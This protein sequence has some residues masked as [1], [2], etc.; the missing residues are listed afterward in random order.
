MPPTPSADDSSITK[1]RAKDRRQA[2]ARTQFWLAGETLMCA[3]PD[4]RAPVSVRQWLMLADCWRCGTSIELNESEVAAAERLMSAQLSLPEPPLPIA[5]GDSPSLLLPTVA[6]SEPVEMRLPVLPTLPRITPVPMPASIETVRPR[7]AERRERERNGNR[8][9]P[10]RKRTAFNW[11]GYFLSAL[12]AW[13]LSTIVHLIAVIILALITLPPN[14]IDEDYQI[15]LSTNI[16]TD[17]RYG[18]DAIKLPS[19]PEGELDLPPPSKEDLNDPI[20]RQAIIEADQV[21]KE[22]RVDPAPPDVPL[23]PI[24]E[25]QQRIGRE[26]GIKA[27]L[28]ARDPRLRVELVK[29]EGG[30]SLT[31]ASVARGLRWLANHQASDGCWRLDEFHH[32]GNCNC[33]Q[34]GSIEDDTAGTSLALLPFLGAGQTQFTGRYRKEVSGG[35]AWLVKKQKANGDLRSHTGNSG[36]YAHGQG[37]IVLCEAFA[38]TGDEALRRPAQRSIDFIV[39]AQYHDGGWRYMPGPPSQAGDTSVVGWQLMALQSARAAGLKVP[40]STL[41]RASKYLDGVSR[42]DRSLYSYQVNSS[43]THVM[44]AEALLCRVYLGWQRDEPALHRG[45]NWLTESNA[46]K[47]D[48]PDIYY[49]Y[50]GTQAMHH[51]GGPMWDTWNFKMRDLLVQSQ[52]KNGH[53]AG[54]WSPRGPHAEVGGRI[55]MT[56]LSVCTLEVYYRHLPIFRKIET[57]EQ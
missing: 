4:C 18:G 33:G 36:M 31:E 39:A 8:S 30:T 11:L 2:A 52:Q 21:A 16:R 14:L 55:Y 29:K 24:E 28:A 57:G 37:A 9:A 22:L 47:A 34:R 46:P 51:Y 27:S 50:Y 19:D 17:K 12:P 7:D 38:M 35:L 6:A 25:V 10:R 56:A 3:C 32:D 54:S 42:Q 15:L 48:D 45:L 43:P 1:E 49:W 40:D 5:T 53:A 20:K 23:P 26:D 41:E 44:T 13:M